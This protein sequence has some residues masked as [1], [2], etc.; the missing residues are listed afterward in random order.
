MDLE[1][2]K[3]AVQFWEDIFWSIKNS[4][5]TKEWIM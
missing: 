3:S 5:Q 2:E 4:L 1:K